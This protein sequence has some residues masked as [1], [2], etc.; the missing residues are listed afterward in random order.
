MGTGEVAL[1]RAVGRVL[2]RWPS[3]GLAV[4]VVS[5]GEPTWFHCHGV[6]DVGTG[7][8]VTP[9]TVFRVG[10][11]TKTFTAVAVMQLWEQGRVDLDAPANDYLSTVRLRPARPSLEPATVRH[12]LTHTSGV[13]YWLRLSDLLRPASGAG[14]EAHRV[15][16]LGAYYRKGIRQEVQPGSKWVYSNHGFATL[17]QLVEDVSGQALRDYL[18]D[19]VLDPLGM[20]H[21]DLSRSERV[22]PQLATGYVLRRRGLLPAPVRE[23]PTPGGGGLYSTAADLARYLRCLLEGGAG[24][25]GRILEPATVAQLFTPHYQ[26]DARLPGMGL[27]FDLGAEDGRRVAAKDGVVS[28]FLA[29]MAL[30]PSARSGVLAL[31]NTGGLSGRGAPVEVVGAVLRGVLGLPEDPVRH[32][33]APRP[34]V[35]GQLCGWYAP[36]PGVVTNLFTRALMGAGAEV[37]VEG[38]RLVLKP[39]T[40]IPALRRGMTL[41]PDDAKD[42]YAFRVDFSSLGMGTL[43]VVFATTDGGGAAVRLWLGLMGFDKRPDARNPRRLVGAAL[44]AAA[45]AGGLT[46]LNRRSSAAETH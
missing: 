3:A 30:A 25:H 27:G 20:H 29:A 5:P 40:P 1:E 9:D 6:S 14:V 18:R 43:P 36:A 8:P 31:A 17:G 42:P 44:A 39:L 26:P 11:L 16:P 23:V 41:H 33:I 2:E 38:R 12:L 4:A 15:Q 46:R 28:G 13:G 7:A 34:D 32:D 19:R 22:S 24:P 35:W 37:L 10:S 45:V 21:T